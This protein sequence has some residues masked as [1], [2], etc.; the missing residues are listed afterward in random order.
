LGNN[1]NGKKN[2]HKKDGK[3]TQNMRAREDIILK[4]ELTVL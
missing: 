2:I 4:R 1:K 3:E